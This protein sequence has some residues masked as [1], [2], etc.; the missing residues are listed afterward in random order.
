MS[1]VPAATAASSWPRNALAWRVRRTAR[2]PR[3]EER[4][5]LGV[6]RL[7]VAPSEIL[8]HERGPFSLHREREA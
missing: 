6:V 2:E 3:L 4:V 1:H 8:A 7:R 5:G